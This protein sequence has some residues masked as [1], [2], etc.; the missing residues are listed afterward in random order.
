MTK[1]L[2]ATF[3]G[4][5]FAVGSAALSHHKYAPNHEGDKLEN[6]H[7]TPPENTETTYGSHGKNVPHV[8]K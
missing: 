3:L 6:A 5:S 4:V 7:L 8:H 2:A 1:L